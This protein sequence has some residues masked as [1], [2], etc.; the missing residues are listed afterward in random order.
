MAK[1]SERFFAIR[2]LHVPDQSANAEPST[3]QRRDIG[4]TA[5]NPKGQGTRLREFDQT[6]PKQLIEKFGYHVAFRVRGPEDI[7]LRSIKQTQLVFLI[8]CCLISELSKVQLAN[9][10]RP[11]REQVRI[12]SPR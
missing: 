11:R 8:G 1:M 6:G 5:K 10:T 4:P 9:A 3:S 7:V 2:R 12:H